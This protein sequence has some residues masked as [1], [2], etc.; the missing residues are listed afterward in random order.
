MASLWDDEVASAPAEEAPAKR[1]GLWDTFVKAIRTPLLPDEW[2]DTPGELISEQLEKPRTTRPGPRSL[3][4]R[5]TDAALEAGLHNPLGFEAD[6]RAILEQKGYKPEQIN[7]MERK[8]SEQLAREHEADPMIR[9]GDP[10]L[11]ALRGAADLLGGVAGGF[12]LTYPL[13]PGRNAIQRV[14]G[15]VG[16]NALQDV[17]AQAVEVERDVR[18]EYD[19]WQTAFAGTGGAAIQ[20]GSEVAR[21]ARV[22]TA[23]A[24]GAKETNLDLAKDIGEKFGTVTSTIRSAAKNKQVGGAKNSYHL[25]G[26]AIDIARGKGVTHRQIV[27]AY[28]RAG[29]DIIESLDE[30]DHS[31]LAF[32]FGKNVRKERNAR[33]KEEGRRMAAMNADE[34]EVQFAKDRAMLDDVANQGRREIFQAS[35]PA[36]FREGGPEGVTADDVS[37]EEPKAP[38]PPHLRGVISEQEWR[39]MPEGMRQ[40]E[41]LRDR[42][43]QEDVTFPDEYLNPTRPPLEEPK[44]GPEQWDEPEFPIGDVTDRNGI[45]KTYF[46][47]QTAV[48]NK[49]GQLVG[50]YPN[51]EMARELK[52]DHIYFVDG[53]RISDNVEGYDY[54]KDPNYTPP[55]PP[56]PPMFPPRPGDTEAERAWEEAGMVSENKLFGGPDDPEGLQA[57]MAEN[58]EGLDPAGTALPK[59]LSVLKKAKKAGAKERK[60]VREEKKKRVAEARKVRNFTEGEEGQYAEKAALKGKY[61]EID[62]EPLRPYMTT[63]EINAIIK[64]IKSSK[65][66]EYFEGL[67]ATDA[68]I[69]LLDGKLPTKGEMELLYRVHPELVKEILDKRPWGEKAKDYLLRAYETSRGQMGSGDVS[70]SGRQGIMMFTRPAYW[71]ATI[72]QF[73]ALSPTRGDEVLDMQTENIVQNPHYG[74]SKAAGLQHMDTGGHGSRE[75]FAT[76]SLAESIPVLGQI[77]KASN[78]A[79]TFA[80]NEIRY[81]VFYDIVNRAERLGVDIDDPEWLKA[82]GDYINVFTGRAAFGKGKVGNA[83]NSAM[84]ALNLVLFA[85]RFVFSTFQRLNPLLWGR[86]AIADYKTGSPVILKEMLRDSTAYV[87]MVGGLLGLA[88]MAGYD[89]DWD[90]RSPTGLKIKHGKTT[91]D[92]GGGMVQT[93]NFLSKMFTGK[94]ISGKGKEGDLKD[95]GFG[96]DTHW[97]T[98]ARFVRTK[99]HPT[100]GMLVNAKE[101]EDVVGRK[102]ELSEDIKRALSPMYLNTVEEH[103]KEHGPDGAIALIPALFGM[104][105]SNYTPPEKESKEADDTFEGLW[106]KNEGAEE[107]LDSLWNEED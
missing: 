2:Y 23:I 29:Y 42:P 60:L 62:I 89:V 56:E 24:R 1:S 72:K 32:N 46:Q 3:P 64:G 50:Y 58:N 5:A 85:P 20:G 97:S 47:G 43:P 104:G 92:V 7:A 13:A 101:G 102:F 63:P 36:N 66:L 30:G 16:V 68:F 84:P 91:Y 71:K 45:G 25:S 39:D 93:V 10:R 78:R 44:F 82:L 9:G 95:A 105:L 88:G 27:Q 74:R 79:Y 94:K 38:V 53:K 41:A 61:P 35:D 4:Q 28:R 77:P 57:R 80:G 100:L 83:L 48:H 55:A 81:G 70:F 21:R 37:F 54:R 26:Q 69:G 12:D 107:R 106:G 103:I 8:L 40:Q 90:P 19:P 34:L 14:G 51:L 52:P 17:G 22:N 99:L 59:L 6:A 76:H 11:S 75:E 96:E 65:K 15:Q 49:Q 86:A 73:A 18:D 31:H 98:L 87:G 33:I 67:N